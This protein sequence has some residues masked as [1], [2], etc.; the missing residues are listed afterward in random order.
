MRVV[1]ERG[2]IDY[3]LKLLG[4]RVTEAE[5]QLIAKVNV[6]WETMWPKWA[7]PNDFHSGPESVKTASTDTVRLTAWQY[8]REYP[9]SDLRTVLAQTK[10][11][12]GA[13]TDGREF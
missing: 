9:E 6:D 7:L 10:G 1:H 3:R 4:I 2:Y 13:L 5:C 12:D 8:V 11:F